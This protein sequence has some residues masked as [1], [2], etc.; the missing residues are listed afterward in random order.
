MKFYILTTM[1]T[2]LM[3]LSTWASTI[4]PQ[5]NYFQFVDGKKKFV[6]QIYKTEGQ[7][8]ISFGENCVANLAKVTE[9]RTDT[10]VASCKKGHG[11]SQLKYSARL[12]SEPATGRT[13]LYF[14]AEPYGDVD[15]GFG[16]SSLAIK[17]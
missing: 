13:L 14:R 8:R 2:T 5:G 1:T 11:F 12:V 10:W 4:D 6:A 15:A 9:A 3:T 7:L 17:L 16:G